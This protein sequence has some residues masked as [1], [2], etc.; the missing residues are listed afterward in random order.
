VSTDR[1]SRQWT[2]SVTN[3]LWTVFLT[4]GL[5]SFSVRD[6]RAF[7]LV[8]GDVDPDGR[9]HREYC[10]A[11]SITNGSI[12]WSTE[13]E[14]QPLPVWLYTDTG[15][16]LTTD[17]GPRS[18]PTLYG[19]SVYV[20]SSHLKLWRLNAT[21]GAVIWSTNLLEGF[22]G[23]LLGWKNS[24]SPLVDNGLIFVNANGGSERIL[25]IRTS[26]GTLA[27]RSQN[28]NMSYSTPVV[29]TLRGVRQLVFITQN[30]ITLNGL[31]GLE[32]ETGACYW[33]APAP[34]IA[35]P[36]ASP[37][38]Y[39]NMIFVASEY[40]LGSYVTRVDRTNDTWTTTQLWHNASL[41]I[42]WMTPVCR[43]GYLYGPMGHGSELGFA[44]QP[45]R[46]IHMATGTEQWSAGVFGQGSVLLVNNDILGVTERGDLLLFEANPGAYTEI[47]RF[48]AIQDCDATTNKCWNAPAVADGRV[49]VRSTAYAAA[50]D[51]S[52]ADLEFAPPQ[53]TPAHQI[54]L[55][56]RTTD[57]T[58]VG[59]NRLSSM[60]VCASTNLSAPPASWE[61]LTN[62][63]LPTNG[64][65]RITDV[66]AASPQRY[67]I[68][69][70]PN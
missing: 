11:L 57:G 7:T 58:P 64:V 29:A 8:A 39:S 2:G 20:L 12:L 68:V 65:V 53:L 47:G 30:N 41:P 27:W 35:P 59:S 51:L 55:T 32:P 25:A 70:E 24:A 10:I 40:G 54:Q 33:R 23:T 50:F 5:G 26:D 15:G 61:A 46:C 42:Y 17:D 14:H 45:L 3:P 31:V 18:T 37:V 66:E 4:N 52:V 1:I 63:L 69:R 56:V 48:Q 60:D 19:D 16:A 22:M 34:V 43:D 44:S 6:G 49:Y 21:D 67:F 36:M 38:V 9:A 62:A 13:V 28:E